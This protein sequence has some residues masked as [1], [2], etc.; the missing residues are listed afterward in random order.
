MSPP[1][2]TGSRASAPVSAAVEKARLLPVLHALEGQLPGAAISVDTYKADVAAAALDAGAEVVN[3]VSGGLLD[4]DILDVVAR[5]GAAVVLGHLRG[6]PADMREHASYV[7]VVAEVRAELAERIARA[8]E[9]GIPAE[10]ILVDPGLGFAKTPAHN[11]ALLAGLEAIV[12][13]GHAVV[14]GGSRKLFLGEVT[15]RPVDEREFAGAAFHAIAVM[16]GARVLRVHD[17]AAQRDAALV[18]DR[19]RGA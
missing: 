9:A 6:T 11:W 5:H 10:R 8:R 18:A 17:V 1:L 19:A 15:G 16:R 7:D 13:L 12:S 2:M 4:P 3:D 14:I